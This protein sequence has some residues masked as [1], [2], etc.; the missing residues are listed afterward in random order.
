[1]ASILVENKA[2]NSAQPLRPKFSLGGQVLCRYSSNPQIGSDPQIQDTDPGRRQQILEDNFDRKSADFDRKSAELLNMSNQSASVRSTPR[3]LNPELLMREFTQDEQGRI[4]SLGATDSPSACF[5]SQFAREVVQN[6]RRSSSTA[7]LQHQESNQYPSVNSREKISSIENSLALSA[8]GQQSQLTSGLS[9]LTSVHSGGNN[10]IQ[11]GSSTSSTSYN[12][13]RRSLTAS[14]KYRSQFAAKHQQANQQP[15]Q[16]DDSDSTCEE[17]II[18]QQRSATSKRTSLLP[19]KSATA[20]ALPPS[21]A[22][23]ASNTI[24][25]FKNSSKESVQTEGDV[26]DEDDENNSLWM[27]ATQFSQLLDKQETLENMGYSLVNKK[28]KSKQQQQENKIENSLVLAQA[29]NLNI[30]AAASYLDSE[31]LLPFAKLKQTCDDLGFTYS[32]KEWLQI[33]KML[34]NSCQTTKNSSNGNGGEPKE[35][36]IVVRSEDFFSAI[37]TI[38]SNK[39]NRQRMSGSG[40]EVKHHPNSMKSDSGGEM[41]SCRSSDSELERELH[42]KEREIQERDRELTNCYR[43]IAERDTELIKVRLECQRLL[44]DNRNLRDQLN[45][46]KA[47]TN[48]KKQME[49]EKEIDS[50]KWHLSVMENSRKSYESA[51]QQLVSFLEHVTT[52][53]QATSPS[54]RKLFEATKA[55]VLKTT[56]QGTKNYY[57]HRHSLGSGSATPDSMFRAESM[58]GLNMRGSMLSL[59]TNGGD[60]LSVSSSSQSH[61]QL[62]ATSTMPRRH[63]STS[64][65]ASSSHRHRNVNRS[66]STHSKRSPMP[67]LQESTSPEADYV[68]TDIINELIKEQDISNGSSNS[69]HHQHHPNAAILE[70]PKSVAEISQKENGCV[71]KIKGDEVSKST[72]GSA[73][74]KRSASTVSSTSAMTKND[75]KPSDKASRLLGIEEVH[76]NN[77]S[78]QISALD[79][80]RFSMGSS[81][82]PA[83]EKK[84]IICSTNPTTNNSTT[85]I[86]L[87]SEDKTKFKSLG[88]LHMEKGLPTVLV[89]PNDDQDQDEESKTSLLHACRKM[90]KNTKK[91]L[92]RETKTLE[93]TPLKASKSRSSLPGGGQ[94]QT[95]QLISHT[96]FPG[97]PTYPVLAAS[98]SSPWNC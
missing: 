71:I 78:P 17:T 66:Q 36:D 92:A 26:D 48:P 42:E 43:T 33:R 84:S 67:S 56:A 50:L 53:L 49:M 4:D 20:N 22:A 29:P 81:L 61:S 30:P 89:H 11:S 37:H 57:K 19:D 6:T 15:G 91:I 79:S 7:V 1:M 8:S 75:R 14:S 95:L 86:L 45:D 85:S 12:R 10:G 90:L 70:R 40:A 87:K 64:S 65:S 93:I 16:D 97:L 9:T 38:M 62:Q 73:K 25:Q 58:P 35:G 96:T 83:N 77:I 54:Q 39:Q 34:Q 59:S 23:S 51:T 82:S 55:Q 24:K 74:P 47:Y 52:M 2:S 69:R 63:G 44:E 98:H 76:C 94:K 41:E 3:S 68:N 80:G 28:K 88:D 60:N 31:A 5:Q 13:N 18:M 46:L 72:S 27:T 21:T 32:D